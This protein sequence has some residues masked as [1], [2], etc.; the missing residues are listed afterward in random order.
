MV[1]RF[2]GSCAIINIVLQGG[3]QAK[4]IFET[5]DL[6]QTNQ[7]NK[8]FI[9]LN[10]YGTNLMYVDKYINMCMPLVKCDKDTNISINLW[11][12]RPLM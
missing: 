11:D 4:I 1:D 2:R 9:T 5:Q 12:V 7:L 10:I 8:N 3:F 6:K